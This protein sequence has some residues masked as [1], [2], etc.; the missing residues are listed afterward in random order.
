MELTHI[1]VLSLVQG[2]TEFLPISSSAH[3]I[4]APKFF[5]WLDQG[6]W[7]DLAVH[8]GSLFAILVYFRS[9]V[10][11]LLQG[12]F[13]SFSGGGG[14]DARLSWMLIIATIPAGLAGLLFESFFIEYGRS[15][16]TIAL[17]NV[18]FSLLLWVSDVR[19]SR[20]L[21]LNDMTYKKACIIGLAQAI[22][23]IPGTS[24]SGVTMTCALFLGFERRVAAEF[25]FLL[26]IPLIAAASLFQ[27]IRLLSEEF[28]P[29]EDFILG[30]ALSA[31]AA[32]SCIAI[33]LRIINKL[34]MLPFVIYRLALGGVLLLFFFW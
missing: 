10:I 28:V 25:S 6:I 29:W 16:L 1:F 30:A 14:V 31:I 15:I 17:A 11:G 18:F 24:R 3:L 12:W 5:S 20:T 34:S 27:V 4:L 23:L 33:F 19:G 9:R 32:Y 22:A 26:S 13:M 21:N 8:A 2:L 7:F